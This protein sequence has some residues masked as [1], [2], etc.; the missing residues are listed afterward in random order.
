L[1]EEGS[2][3]LETYRE[4]GEMIRLIQLLDVYTK[5]LNEGKRIQ[6]RLPSVEMYSDFSGYIHLDNRDNERVNFDNIDEVITKMREL[7]G[8]FQSA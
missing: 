6:L 4:A 1:G 2:H 3:T 5:A 8:A 7:I